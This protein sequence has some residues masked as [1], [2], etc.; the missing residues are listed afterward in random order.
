MNISDRETLLTPFAEEMDKATPFSEYPRPSMVR[1]SYMTLNGAW[2]F[3][4]TSDNYPKEYTAK[5]LVPFPPESR[6]SGYQDE[7]PAGAR[8]FYKRKF[9]LPDGFNEGKILLNVGA[10]DTLSEIFIN[11]LKVSEHEG[12]YLPFSV[13]I[14]HEL[15]IGENEIVIAATDNLDKAYPYGKQTRSRGGMWY[16]PVSGIWQSVWLESVPI[17]Y[18][19]KLKITSK[20]DRAVIEVV[21]GADEKKLTLSDGT[22]YEWRGACFEIAPSNVI[23]WTP[24]NPY[25][26]EFTLECGEDKVSSYFA[27]RSIEA[28]KV[29]GTPRIL[30]N[31]EPYLFN[32]LLD[33]GY[34]PDGLFLPATSEG[35]KNDILTAKKLGFNMLRKHIKIEPEIFY[36]LCDKLGMAVF[37]DMVNNSGYS[38]ILDT[39]LPTVGF[40]RIPDKF[41]HRNKRTREIFIDHAL[42]TLEHLYSHPCIVY[43]TIFNEGWGQF[44]ADEVYEIVKEAEPE[45]II[46][47]TSGW[48]TE[49][50]SDVD[51]RHVYFKPVKLGKVGDRPVVISEFGGY[52][53]RVEGH[54]FGEGNYGYRLFKTRGEFEDAF[55]K[56]YSEEIAP[57]VPLGISALVYTQVSD[58]ED[59]T[60]GVM[61]YDRR[62]LKLNPERIKPIMDTLFNSIKGER[63]L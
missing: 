49:K 17:Q 55:V 29:N 46:D 34:F 39:V 38:F 54:L 8:M 47:A 27:L 4:V 16:T 42:K 15:K 59:E 11:G 23:N 61:T 20:R 60:N 26:Y 24:E 12:G 48:F 31:G 32:G 43:Y 2:N 62:V 36:Y 58:I 45:R 57:L 7:I 52:S 1:K 50:K 53:Y 28:K 14:T 44:C 21:G 22:V 33:Q 41:R 10:V 40:K 56:L 37:Q 6:L 5:I 19:E 51:S 63:T 30:L 25:L 3:A 18:I 35:Y 13:D 9:T